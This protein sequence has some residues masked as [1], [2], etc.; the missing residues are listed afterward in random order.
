MKDKIWIYFRLLLFIPIFIWQYHEA[1]QATQ[2][3]SES[4]YLSIV[5]AIIGS[6]ILSNLINRVLQPILN[7]SRFK[8]LAQA[9]IVS[10]SPVILSPFTSR[11]CLLYAFYIYSI[12]T[13]YSKHRSTTFQYDMYG[14]YSGD[15]YLQID[16]REI[17][18]PKDKKL[19]F[20]N[21]SPIAISSQ[22]NNNFLPNVY[23]YIKSN[24]FSL[25]EEPPFS[26]REAPGEDGTLEFLSG[27]TARYKMHSDP[28]DLETKSIDE[29]VVPIGQEVVIEELKSIDQAQES[30]NLF[31]GTIEEKKKKDTV[32]GVLS[33][34]IAIVISVALIA[35]EY[36]T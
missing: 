9:K 30:I 31:I 17:P 19:I 28:F 36:Y 11:N 4:H 14:V 6:L 26:S 15:L 1:Q 7:I 2:N 22:E 18:I 32:N 16:G 13:T 5:L 27:Q 25:A 24:E 29:F 10:K 12:R 21:L 33:L 20:E 8:N 3:I 34:I 35:I 23:E